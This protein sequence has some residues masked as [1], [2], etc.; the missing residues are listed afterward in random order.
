MAGCDED[1]VGPSRSESCITINGT[2]MKVGQAIHAKGT[3]VAKKG[4]LEK[5]FGRNW[6]SGL[7]KKRKYRVEWTSFQPPFVAEYAAQHRIFRRETECVPSKRAKTCVPLSI[8]SA[9][10]ETDD[11]D[12]VS[13][14]EEVST[15]DEEPPDAPQEVREGNS[16]KVGDRVWKLDPSLDSVDP[17]S[18]EDIV[19]VKPRL[20]WQSS[21]KGRLEVFGKNVIDYFHLMY[22]QQMQNFIIQ[23]A[24]T[25]LGENG[26][27]DVN[28]MD[29]FIGCLLGMSVEP[30]TTIQDYWKVKDDGFITAN[31]FG[32][33][34]GMS[35]HRWEQ[36]RGA[37]A[38]WEGNAE[39]AENR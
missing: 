16:I 29:Q 28:E 17:R 4:E 34:T 25:F 23:N 24:N 3:I 15:D 32:E 30:L 22:S 21:S 5:I 33:K 6:K 36:I 38:F 9:G 37:L 8:P 2:R 13:S 10:E 20:N 19:T 27:L 11:S 31:R 12:G 26:N 7:G 18:I 39:K 14:S 1:G 35:K